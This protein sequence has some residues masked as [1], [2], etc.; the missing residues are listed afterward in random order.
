MLTTADLASFVARAAFSDIPEECL[1]MA[2]RA[3]LD[4]TG[5]AAAGASEE[6]SRVSRRALL[7]PGETGSCT[8]IG[9]GVKTSP[10]EA[11]FFNGI[12]GHALDFDDVSRI[13]RG[14]PSVAVAPA[15]LALSEHLGLGGKALLEAYVTGIEVCHKIGAVVNNSHYEKGWHATSTIGVFGATAASA[16]LLGLNAEQTR[17]AL[18]IAASAA[19][20]LRRNFGTMTKP[21]HAGRAARSGVTAALL[22]R[23]GMTAHEAALESP[24]GFFELYADALS[25]QVGDLM[26]RWLMLTP[27]LRFKK[28]PCCSNIH[29]SID[30]VLELLEKER[31]RPEDVERIVCGVYSTVPGI[32][33]DRHPETG[34][35]AQFS[36]EYCVA[37]ALL[38]GKVELGDFTDEAVGRPEVRQMMPK[39]KMT[40]SE[41]LQSHEMS[42]ITIVLKGG[43]VFSRKV[44]VPKGHPLNPVSDDELSAKYLSLAV[45]VL[46]A[47]KAEESMKRIGSLENVEDVRRLTALL[48]VS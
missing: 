30:A 13:M 46:G 4:F 19:A 1:R 8:V 14:H 28:Y 17:H 2:K 18:G 25:D 35:Q 9:T 20:G 5:V 39:I 3:F 37:V 48:A 22:A 47:R 10:P 12:A 41:D 42:E 26:S 24:G 31:F 7:R 27:G 6:V 40:V 15:A 21:F 33:T 36:L 32:L 34:T 11:A 29:G 38:Y 16:K 45:P 44:A 43:S 23:E